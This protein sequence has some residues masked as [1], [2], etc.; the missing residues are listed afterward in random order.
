MPR[1]PWSVFIPFIFS[2]WGLANE[3][4]SS[5]YTIDREG[6]IRDLRTVPCAQNFHDLCPRLLVGLRLDPVGLVVENGGNKESR[7]LESILDIK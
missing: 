6:G 4:G 7:S 2:V 1:M 5:I 3:S